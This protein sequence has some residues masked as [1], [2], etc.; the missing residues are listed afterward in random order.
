MRQ[1]N[2]LHLCSVLLYLHANHY[3]PDL[4]FLAVPIC[5]LFTLS[6]DL[7]Y[8]GYV[9]FV[10]NLREQSVSLKCCLKGLTFTNINVFEFPPRE[11]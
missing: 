6:L 7:R 11:Y 8:N 2:A 3:Y 1:I 4:F 9:T 10:A 5:V